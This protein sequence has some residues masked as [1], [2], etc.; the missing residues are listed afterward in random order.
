MTKPPQI[1]VADDDRSVRMVIVH[2]LS[3]QGYQVMAASTIASM[4]DLLQAGTAELLVTDIGF[5]DGDALELL[6]RIQ[7]KYPD[8][9]IIMMSARAN[10]L[11][12][13]KTQ[14]NEDWP[15]PPRSLLEFKAKSKKSSKTSSLLKTIFCSFS[16]P[17]IFNSFSAVS[18]NFLLILS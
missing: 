9:T 16:T 3:K 18:N 4:W 17:I 12:A 10:L 1:I 14:Q 5:P 8:M 13:I 2:A 6:P 7:D 15:T 11:T